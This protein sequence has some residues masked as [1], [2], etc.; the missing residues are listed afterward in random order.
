MKELRD[1]LYKA[2]LKESC[3]SDVQFYIDNNEQQPSFNSYKA[4]LTFLKAN[5]TINPFKKLSVFKKGQKEMDEAVK[6]SPND[7]ETR[8][9]RLSIQY[10]IPTFLDYN[11]NKKEDTEFIKKHIDEMTDEHLKTLILK[12]FKENKL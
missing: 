7:L 5:Y 6:L 10:K 1:L 12:F 4:M 3:I 9:L 2:T 8:F 11:K